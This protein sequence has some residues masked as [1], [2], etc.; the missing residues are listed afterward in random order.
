MSVRQICKA[1]EGG[2]RGRGSGRFEIN[3]PCLSCGQKIQLEMFSVSSAEISEVMSV[4]DCVC[5]YQCV[6]SVCIA[7]VCVCDLCVC[8]CVC[9]FRVLPGLANKRD[10]ANTFGGLTWA[11]AATSVCCC[12]HCCCCCY[13]LATHLSSSSSSVITTMTPKKTP[14]L[15]AFVMRESRLLRLASPHLALELKKPCSFSRV[16]NTRAALFAQAQRSVCLCSCDKAVSR[17]PLYP[18]RL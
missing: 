8:L 13:C 9:D 3:W 10:W 7:G 1:E 17:C 4:R 2:G 5:V 18:R 12:C 15:E 11:A 6:T 16:G 14:H